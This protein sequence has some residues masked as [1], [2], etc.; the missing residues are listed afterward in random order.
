MKFGV[1]IFPSK[2]TQDLVNSYRKRY[3]PHYSLIPPHLTLKGPFDAEESDLPKL[4]EQLKDAAKKHRPF[5][6]QLSKVKSFQPLNNVIYIKVEPNE[7]L[8]MMNEE[9]HGDHVVGGPAEYAYVP[10]LTVAQKLSDAE[11]ADVYNSLNMLS[12]D[13]EEMVDRFHLLY[14]LEN[15]AWTVHETFLLREE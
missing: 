15:G 10:H 2:K 3:D 8:T 1:V 6:Y 14:Q 13:Q 12:F 11:H 5:T 9:L 4:V 7:A